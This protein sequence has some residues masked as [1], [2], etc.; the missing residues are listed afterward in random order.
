RRGDQ[1]ETVGRPLLRR[2]RIGC[3]GDTQSYSHCRCVDFTRRDRLPDR[4]RHGWR[5]RIGGGHEKGERRG[6]RRGQESTGAGGGG[7]GTGGGGLGRGKGR[8]RCAGG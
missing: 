4:C 1:R 7:G 2:P 6:G 5:L 8:G 3:A